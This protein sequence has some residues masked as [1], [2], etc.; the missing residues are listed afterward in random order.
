MKIYILICLWFAISSVQLFSEERFEIIVDENLVTIKNTDILTNCC[1]SFQSELNINNNVISITQR[2]TSIQ[3]CKCMCNFDLSYS[4][5]QIPPGNYTLVIYRE[6]YTKF[7]YNE[8]KKYQ[9]HKSKFAVESSQSKSPLSFD[10]KQTPCKRNTESFQESYPK[11]GIE[12][13]PN[14]ASSYVTVRFDMK[15][16]GDA[17]IRVLNFLGKEV[18]ILKR[19]NLSEGIQTI[20]FEMNDIPSGFYVGK[21]TTS[22]GQNY[23]FKIAWSK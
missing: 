1:S 4:I 7:G 16:A 10:F 22:S 13:Y 9:V 12:V 19:F 5:S 11:N 6:E 8:Y 14:P 18:A 20:S 3:K 2:D 23:S 15:K 17:S 21:L